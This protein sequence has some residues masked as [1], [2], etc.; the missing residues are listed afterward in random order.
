MKSQATLLLSLALVASAGLAMAQPPA[1]GE[2]GGDGPPHERRGGGFLKGADADED[3]TV[4]QDEFKKFHEEMF[5]KG[6]KN[7][8]GKLDRD[9]VLAM[10]P[11]RGGRQGGIPP[12][13]DPEMRSG[14]SKERGQFPGNRDEIFAMFDANDDGKLDREEAP[15]PMAEHFDLMD[16]NKD[17]SLT[18][19]ELKALRPEPGKVKERVGEL[20]SRMD[21]DGDGKIQKSEAGPRLAENFDKLDSNADGAI[22]QEELKLFQPGGSRKGPG[23]KAGK[24]AQAAPPAAS[25][26]PQGT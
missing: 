18:L 7:G 2:G 12:A 13:P 10:A 20:L 22:D 24:P 6:D 1:G 17:G 19:E 15:G 16:T 4:T 11:R 5:K 25:P 8:D 21:A 3:G 26:T 23:A 9:E 14:E